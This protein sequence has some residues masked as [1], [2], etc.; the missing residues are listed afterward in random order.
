MLAEAVGY[1]KS[2][3]L[4]SVVGDYNS[5]THK[6]VVH[7]RKNKSAGPVRYV[8]LSDRGLEA[9]ERLAKGKN[10]GEPLLTREFKGKSMPMIDTR[11]WFDDVLAEAK[12]IDD[13]ASWHVSRHTFCS[14]AVAAGV[15]ITDVKE[16][17]GH[18]DLRTT[19]RYTHGVEGVSDVRNREALNHKSTQQSQDVS[20]L[21]QQIAALTALVE[22]LSK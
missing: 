7:Q 8:P 11:Y 13:A 2:E 20:A 22:R 3:Q 1:R 10:P 15:P 16:Y 5:L 18:S 17:A 6:I 19:A 9:Y 21:Q 4:R 14:R 12:I